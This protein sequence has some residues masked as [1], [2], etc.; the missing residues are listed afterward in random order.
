MRYHNITQDD[1]RNGDGLRTVLWV[2]GCAHACEGCHNPLTWNEADGLP[3]DDQALAELMEKLAGE[4]IA[5]LTLS[6]GD[7][8]FIHNRKEVLEL[9][10]LVKAKYPQKTIWLYTGYTWEEIA[11]LKILDYIDVLVD[12]RFVAALKDNRLHWRGSKN[13]RVIDVKRSK[14]ENRIILHCG[15]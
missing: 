12:G 8:L 5:G 2:S 6:G 3:F 9:V 14:K 13:Q 10:R 4:H 11:A 7:P 15:E 1:M